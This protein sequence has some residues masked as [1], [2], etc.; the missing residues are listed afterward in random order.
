V[1]PVERLTASERRGDILTA[2]LSLF[3]RHGLHGVTTRQIAEAAG[4]SEALLYRHFRSKEELYSELQKSC[5]SAMTR[6]A[7]KLVQLEP[8]TSTLV[9]AVHYMIATILR[10]CELGERHADLRRLLLGS[11]ASDGEFA[12]GFFRANLTRYV[13]KMV[14][15]IEAAGRVGD[16]VGP[17]SHA[18]L[19]VYFS[20]HI[21]AM[22][23]NT[24]LPVPGAIDY[25][26]DSEVLLEEAVR[27]ALR[28]LG[29]RE[30]AIGRHYNPKALS[31]LV[32]G[33]TID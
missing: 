5:L 22:I 29:V 23:G 33:L 7:E 18:S 21:A 3:A 16:L 14:E 4:V 19:R 25:G 30:E 8:S 26:V 6:I 9:L 27:Y 28:G 17:V 20:H 15:C 12:R 13:P 31:L 24:H 2:S 1:A 10:T 11:L 32:G